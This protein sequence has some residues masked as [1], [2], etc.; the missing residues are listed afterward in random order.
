MNNKKLSILAID[1]G[2]KCGFATSPEQSGVWDLKTKRFE[3]SG[4]RYVNLENALSRTCKSV[5]VDVVVFEEVRRHQGV[6]AAHVYGGF[7]AVIQTY[8]EKH[9]IQ[10]TAVPVGTLKKFATGR[11]NANKDLMVAA[12]QNKWP[13]VDIVDDNH[14]DALWIWAWSQKNVGAQEA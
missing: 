12:A 13:H 10:Y 1:P 8:C 14:A 9:N 7:V 3:S 5:G 4:M 11:G 2:T 6:S